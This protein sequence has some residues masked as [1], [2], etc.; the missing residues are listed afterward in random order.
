MNFGEIVNRARSRCTE[1]LVEQINL[2]QA[3]GYQVIIEPAPRLQGGIAF[4]PDGLKLPLRYD[5]VFQ[6]SLG[7]YHSENAKSTTLNFSESVFVTWEQRLKVEL[8]S[9]CWDYMQIELFSVQDEPGW[10][11]LRQWFLKWFD[12]EDNK[13]AQPNGL[14]GVVHFI[15]DPI[16]KD[17]RV[18][19]FVD[20]GSASS[21]ALAEL[22]DEFIK[23]GSIS[24]IIGKSL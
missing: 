13:K 14:H 5:L 23:L 16:L 21:D 1:S 2:R 11:G 22:F 10:E 17:G 9:L 3:E 18:S 8:R 6:D 7:V 4:A 24:C 12:L 19:L 15:S 20:L